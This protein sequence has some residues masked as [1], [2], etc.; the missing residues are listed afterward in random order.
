MICT[1]CFDAEYKAGKTELTVTLNGERHVLRDLDCEICPACGEITFS[2]AQSLEIDK[3]RIALEFGVKPLLTPEQLKALRRFL[4]MKLDE[5]CDMLHVGRNTYGRWERGEVEITPSMNLLVHNLIEKVPDAQ[6]NVVESARNASIDK[7]NEALLGRYISF[8]EY[9]REAMA[10]TRLRPDVVCTLVGM[11]PAELARI[12]NNE[13]AP[14]KTPP[15]VMARLAHFFGLTKDALKR[16]LSE[17]ATIFAMKGSVTAV[18]ARRPSYD[19]KGAAMQSSSINKILEKLSQKKGADQVRQVVSE[20][21]L[22]K[23]NAILVR[24]HEYGTVT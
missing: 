1:N 4:D 15:E 11:E 10:A 21:Y 18:H 12:Q 24:L 22:A 14:E 9:V 23:V 19:A 20:E 8:G 13:T 5:I 7:A 17:A 2:H 6:V 16:L 3:K